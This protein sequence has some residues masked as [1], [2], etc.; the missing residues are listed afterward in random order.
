MLMRV[1]YPDGRHDFVNGD[2]LTSLIELKAISK[3]KRL[4]GWVDV[5]SL[6]LR[7]TSNNTHYFGTERRS[8]AVASKGAQLT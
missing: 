5:P 8:L 2:I 7:R 6:A 3:F 1:V 4:D